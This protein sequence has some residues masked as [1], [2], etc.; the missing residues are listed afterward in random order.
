[1]QTFDPIIF[2]ALLL[3]SHM[4]KTVIIVTMSS[5]YTRRATVI[6]Q[7]DVEAA[8][9]C[10]F[11]VRV[12]VPRKR[13]FQTVHRRFWC[14]AF[15][16]CCGVHRPT[17]VNTASVWHS[18]QFFHVE[19]TLKIYWSNVRDVWWVAHFLLKKIDCNT[20]LDRYI[21]GCSRVST[22]PLQLTVAQSTFQLR[23][24]V[25]WRA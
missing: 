6:L 22:G 17:H 21:H 4:V 19:S 1:M 11:V 15:L 10:I 20:S 9:A 2:M 5:F 18:T 14:C 12:V 23:S 25:E 16:V 8:V 24:V 13:C 3:L 7:H